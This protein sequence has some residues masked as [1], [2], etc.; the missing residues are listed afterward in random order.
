MSNELSRYD[1]HSPINFMP[2]NYT[3]VGAYHNSYTFHWANLA[4]NTRRDQ[5]KG[6]LA[7]NDRPNGPGDGQCDHCGAA[8]AFVGV[9]QHKDGEYIAVG[10]TCADNRFPMSNCQFQELR[11]AHR[12]SRDRDLR[13]A[14]FAEFKLAH[15]EVDWAA[16]EASDNSRVRWILAGGAKYGSIFEYTLTQLTRLLTPV[17][18]VAPVAAPAPVQA[19]AAAIT[20]LRAYNG[21]NSFLNSLKSQVEAGR[22][23]SPKQL[24]CLE[25]NYTKATTVATPATEALK[26]SNQALTPGIY[27]AADGSIWKVQGNMSYKSGAKRAVQAKVPFDP[28]TVSGAR[29]YALMWAAAGVPQTL[30]TVRD[31]TVTQGWE[32]VRGAIDTLEVDHKMTVDEAREFSNLYSQCVWCGR[33]LE[34]TLS[35]GTKFIEQG[36]G[37]VCIKYIDA[38]IKAPELA[39]EHSHG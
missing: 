24:S 21:Q 36:I 15:P 10:S 3:F 16:A 11:K 33:A 2:E 39:R 22:T 38:T 26:A 18:P 1:I 9:F 29:V 25:Q 23:L 19:E 12:L 32:F 30:A 8:I 31:L 17:A 35:Y 34:D 28:T 7:S 20:W 14:E 4:F 5:L 6:F 37:P 27:I 13:A